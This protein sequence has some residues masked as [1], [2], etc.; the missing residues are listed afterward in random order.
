MV[1]HDKGLLHQWRDYMYN[2]QIGGGQGG[3]RKNERFSLA[4]RQLNKKVLVACM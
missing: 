1:D 3:G 2:G 4:I